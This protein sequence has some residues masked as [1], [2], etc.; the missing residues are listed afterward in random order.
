MEALHGRM[1]QELKYYHNL[2]ILYIF[3]RWIPSG[4]KKDGVD[5]AISKYDGKWAVEEAETSPLAG[6]MGLV[7][8]VRRNME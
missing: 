3:I 4:A 7:L 1:E 8:K 5:D 2:I 6:D